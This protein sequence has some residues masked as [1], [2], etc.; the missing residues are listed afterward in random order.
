MNLACDAF[1]LF[2]LHA[3]QASCQISERFLRLPSFCD[4]DARSYVAGKHSVGT[5]PRH[6]SV[7]HPSV[8][9]IVSPQAI[10]HLEP[11]TS[12]KRARIGMQAPLQIVRVD[13][14]C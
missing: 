12:I 13:I 11:F 4:I 5:E 1:A 8:L 10:L 7:E 2:F 3:D 9:T 6:S 14:V